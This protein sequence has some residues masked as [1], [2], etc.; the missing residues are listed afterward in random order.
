ML[1]RSAGLIAILL[2]PT[3]LFAQ[4]CA[5]CYTQA[6][7]SGSH[8]IQAL[9]SGIVVLVIPPMLICLGIGWMAYKK[10]NQFNE[11]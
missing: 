3:V 7:G 11:D 10:R 9:R 2:S 6:A 8:L 5:L 1:R 4:N